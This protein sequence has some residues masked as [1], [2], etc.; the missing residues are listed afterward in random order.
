[1]IPR[2]LNS[3][4]QMFHSVDLSLIQIF[5]TISELAEQLMEVWNKA[6]YWQYPEQISYFKKLPDA[7]ENDTINGQARAHVAKR[8]TALILRLH[9]KTFIQEDFK[10]NDIYVNLVQ[11]VSFSS[12]LTSVTKYTFIYRKILTGSEKILVSCI[13]RKIN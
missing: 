8:I 4:A 1:M 11:Q 6:V 9:A 5:V 2:C 13:L 10:I 7:L 3:F 12:F